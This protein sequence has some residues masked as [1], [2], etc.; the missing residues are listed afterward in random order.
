MKFYKMH[1][2]GNDYV[3]I[4]GVSEKIDFEKCVSKVKVL[5]AR[6]FG[7]GSD[8]V[9]FLLPSQKA[10][11]RM[12]MYNGED[13]TEAEMCGNGIRCVMK[14]AF[15]LGLLPRKAVI[16]TLPGL[17][18]GEVLDD[19]NV[20]VK[21]FFPPKVSLEKEHVSS[22]DKEFSFTRV[23][24]GNPHA[25]IK[26]ENISSF[27][28]EKYGR[29]IENNLSLFPERTNVEFYEMLSKNKA[30]MRVWERGSGET[31]ACGTGAS[32]TAGVIHQET[33]LDEIEVEMRGGTL[34]FFFDGDDFYMQGPAKLVYV[35]EVDLEKF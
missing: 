25:V 3:Y 29:P 33:G 14:L 7:I 15:L 31:W 8:G 23:N 18:E 1:G 28:V 22:A 30:R 12:R 35:G 21:M 27:E 17:I 4:D 19:E 9:I 13:G 26:E 5:S 32:A 6:R 10:D 20:K 16:E 2:A 24:I 34:S 11:L